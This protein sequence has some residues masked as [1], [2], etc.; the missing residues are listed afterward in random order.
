ML[1]TSL[2]QSLTLEELAFIKQHISPAKAPC[3]NAFFDARLMA[4]PLPLL[5]AKINLRTLVAGQSLY[6][7]ADDPNSQ[8]DLMAFCQKNQHHIQTWVSQDHQNSTI[9]HFIITKHDETKLV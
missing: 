9:F 1:T 7:L 4:C 3:I 8:T 2:S 6:L 5:K